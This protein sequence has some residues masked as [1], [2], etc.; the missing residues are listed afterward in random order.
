[1]KIF[2]L[3]ITTAIL[4]VTGC[5]RTPKTIQDIDPDILSVQER[6]NGGSG[7]LEVVIKLRGL[8]VESDMQGAMVRMKDVSKGIATHF[9]TLHVDELHYVLSADLIDTYGNRKRTN[10]L[11]VPFTMNEVRQ[12]NFDSG[13]LTPWGFMNLAGKPKVLHPAGTEFLVR[14]CKDP[15]NFKFAQSFCLRVASLE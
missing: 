2:V 3:V 12:I 13:Q 8:S 6:Q 9:A 14:Y 15:D 7:A 1:M 5:G 10:V 11:E 4:L